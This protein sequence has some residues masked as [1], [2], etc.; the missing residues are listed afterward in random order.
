MRRDEDRFSDLDMINCF[1]LECIEFERVLIGIESAANGAL[2]DGT[3]LP[4][5]LRYQLSEIDDFPV[6]IDDMSPVSF[7]DDRS[8]TRWNRGRC[9]R[10]SLSYPSSAGSST[11]GKTDSL[12]KEANPRLQNRV[13]AVVL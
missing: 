13:S 3:D 10:E 8:T 4:S 12:E 11:A 9:F 5:H 2:S 1:F 6:D 7:R